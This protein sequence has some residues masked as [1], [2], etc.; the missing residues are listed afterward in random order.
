MLANNYPMPPQGFGPNIHEAMPTRQAPGISFPPMA[1]S[2]LPPTKYNVHEQNTP[3]FSSGRLWDPFTQFQTPVSSSTGNKHLSVYTDAYGEPGQTLGKLLLAAVRESDIQFLNLTY[4]IVYTASNRFSWDKMIAP[5]HVLAPMAFLAPPPTT[6]SRTEHREVTLGMFHLGV[7]DETNFIVYTLAGKQSQL[8]KFRQV[9]QATIRTMLCNIVTEIQRVHQQR[10]M[11]TEVMPPATLVAY[12]TAI[13]QEVYNFAPLCPINTRGTTRDPLAKTWTIMQAAAMQIEYNTMEPQIIIVPPDTAAFSSITRQNKPYGITG[14]TSEQSAQQSFKTVDGSTTAP[15]VLTWPRVTLGPNDGPTQL[16]GN[17]AVFGQYFRS[18]YT[19]C[20][21]P[22]N[23]HSG[24]RTIDTWAVGENRHVARSLKTMLSYC[25]LFDHDWNLTDLGHEFFQGYPTIGHWLHETGTTD[26]LAHPSVMDVFF[27]MY[28]EAVPPEG[29]EKEHKGPPGPVDWD[30][31]R[32]HSVS[33]RFRRTFDFSRADLAAARSRLKRLGWKTSSAMRD[34]MPTDKVYFV[35]IVAHL[36]AVGCPDDI[37]QLLAALDDAVSFG[38]SVDNVSDTKGIRYLLGIVLSFAENASGRDNGLSDAVGKRTPDIRR[39]IA[40][41]D[42]EG[43]E[44]STASIAAAVNELEDAVRPILD[45][46]RKFQPDPKGGTDLGDVVATTKINTAKRNHF[47][48]ALIIHIGKFFH[49]C[50]RRNI[51]VPLSFYIFEPSVT[52]TMGTAAVMPKGI[53]ITAANIPD[54]REGTNPQIKKTVVHFTIT[55]SAI[56][57][58]EESLLVCQ[59]A[60]F[61]TFQGGS[62]LELWKATPQIAQGYRSGAINPLKYGGFVIAVPPDTEKM[63]D[64]SDITGRYNINVDH[65]RLYPT[66]DMYCRY[67]GWRRESPMDRHLSFAM[68]SDTDELRNTVIIQGPQYHYVN[69]ERRQVAGAGHLGA[70]CV[71]GLTEQGRLGSLNSR[72]VPPNRH[73]MGGMVQMV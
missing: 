56:T 66:A 20:G 61:Q 27:G 38:A 37:I 23:Y 9:V 28:P 10:I 22:T 32:R 64:I 16:G 58:H 11:D 68:S 42:T 52:F 63:D 65:P 17:T 71:D 19:E 12:R 2:H 25:G 8:M 34:G 73:F 53:G 4:P 45:V 72:P 13:R 62:Q 54:I 5:A 21:V 31:V 47:F 69:G 33:G 40:Q 57:R 55:T 50:E 15:I 3:G 35:N 51:P 18:L 59:N 70:E 1:T 46:D 14:K 36:S 24:M 29:K 7:E 39:F 49:A 41:R 44:R 30:R 48:E 26:I 43:F 67:W 60:D 6:V